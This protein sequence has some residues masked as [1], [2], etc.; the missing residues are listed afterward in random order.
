MA[1]SL[2]KITLENKGDIH[3]I[4]LSKENDTIYS[5]DYN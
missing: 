2:P 4:D 5:G 3:L 1:I